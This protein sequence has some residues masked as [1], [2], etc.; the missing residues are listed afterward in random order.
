MKKKLFALVVSLCCLIFMAG[1]AMATEEEVSEKDIEKV[2]KALKDIKFNLLWYLSY[3]N[4]EGKDVGGSAGDGE[5][6]N[7]F[8]IKRGYFRFTK[9]L[10]PWMDAHMTFDVTQV[11][12]E[13]S[14]LNG[15]VDVRIKYAYAKFK[16][17]EFAFF[18]HP[19]MEVGIVHM[20][21][22]DFEEHV[23]WFRCQ[24]T[25]FLER[26]STFNSAD[27]GLTVVS[28]LG[29]E[30]NEEYQK[31]VNNKYPGRYGSLAFGVYNGGGYHA[32]EEN[33]NKVFEGRLTIRPLPDIVPGLQLSY[34]GIIGKGNKETEPDWNVNLGMASFEHE[35]IVLTGQYY[36]GKGNQ[37]GTDEYN[38]DGYSIFTEIKPHKKISV[39]GRYDYFDPNDDADD[40]ENTRYIFGIAYHLDKPHKNMIVLDYDTVQYEDNTKED[41][42]RVQLT[43]QVAL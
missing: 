33:G 36:D 34:F 1:A 23:N 41:D 21:W 11:K 43:L 22:L 40:D 35:Y 7:K 15:S 14:S 17:P 27:F 42:K 24:D 39:I 25:M 19:F 29:G 32:S 31:K 10:M 28:L 4:G 8:A 5:S 26:N 30:I 2:V 20:P 16:F 3:M 9:A 12:D 6:H 18:T 37:K 38:K 13:D